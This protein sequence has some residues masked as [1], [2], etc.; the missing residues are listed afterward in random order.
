MIYSMTPNERE[1][2]SI[3]N[4]SRRKRI[5]KGSGATIQ[6]LNKLLKQFD[7]TSKMMKMMGNKQNMM[8]M[9]KNMPKMPGGFGR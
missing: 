7:Q 9:M 4:G 8:K 3:I 2:P 1:N 5:A 6:D